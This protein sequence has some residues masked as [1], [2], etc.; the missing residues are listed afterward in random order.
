M[1]VPDL[2]SLACVDALARTLRFH[3]AARSCALSPAAFSKRVQQAEEQLGVALFQ[4]STRRVQV[5]DRGALL[6]PRIRQILA[7]AQALTSSDLALGAVDV[8][9]GTRH[10]LGMSWLMPARA[11]IK[12]ALPHVTTHLRFGS[13]EELEQSVQ[14]LRTDAIVISR[15][16]ATRRLLAVDLHQEAYDLVAAPK[17]LAR[18]PLRRAADA[19]A[20]VLVDADDSLPLFS[21]FRSSGVALQFGRTLTLGAIEAILAAV[22]AGE[23]VAVLPRYFVR[24]HLRRR[25]LRRLL[26][27]AVLGADYFRMIFRADDPRRAL[28]ERIGAVLAALPLR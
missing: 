21:Y 6:L 23:G 2:E 26:P 15:A 13:T 27:R 8:V 12:R 1:T 18:L 20:H 28:L 7:D 4:R 19:A 10:E 17:L 22:L 25:R 5:T 11:A 3:V 24:E 14:L 16:P 9:I